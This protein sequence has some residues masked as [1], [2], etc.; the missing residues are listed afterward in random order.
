MEQVQPILS[1]QNITKHYG[2][3]CVL[4]G[5]SL[6]LEPG[7]ITGLLGPN[8]AG[9]STLIRIINRILSKDDGEV[10]FQ[11]ISMKDEDLNRIGYLPEERGLYRSMTVM[12]QGVYFAR[13]KGLSKQAAQ[14]TVLQWLDRMAIADWKDKRIQDLSKGMSQKFQ[15]ITA[16]LHNPDLIILDEPFSGFDPVNRKIAHELLIELKAEGKS[17]LLSTHDMESVESLCDEIHLLHNQRFLLSG[18]PEQIKTQHGKLTYKVGFIGADIAFAN[19][20]WTAFEL[21]EI[22]E[23]ESFKEAIIRPTMGND[24]NDLLVAMAAQ[25]EIRHVMSDY[26]SIKDIYLEQVQQRDE[27]ATTE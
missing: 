11:G 19:A 25:L 2:T 1:V 20:L 8:G 24:I 13:L 26:P 6:D 10:L 14:Q 23:G 22:K 27:K 16:L 9:K 17:I 3:S 4:D 5:I 7:K 21:L 15:L 12:E 18:T